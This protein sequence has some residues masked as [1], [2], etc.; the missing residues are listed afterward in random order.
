MASIPAE[1]KAFI[2]PF[3][4]TDVTCLVLDVVAWFGVDEIVSI[5]NQNLCTAIKNIPLSQKALWKQLEPCVNSEKQFITSLGVRILIGRA[6]NIEC[7]PV[8]PPAYPPHT[9]YY[10][11]TPIDFFQSTDSTLCYNQPKFE[12]SQMLHNLGNI[13]INEAV[14]DTRAYPLLDEVNTKINRIY[15]ILVEREQ[16]K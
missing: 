15:N 1:S 2:K 8:P 11:N 14:Y 9:S 10:N 6:Q 12:L 13:F 4:G 3:E 7:V 5:L 16:V